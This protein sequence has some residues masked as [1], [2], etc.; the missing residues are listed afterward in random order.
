M[1]LCKE[2]HTEV[3]TERPD[4]FPVDVLRKFKSDHEARVYRLTGLSKDRDTVA[5]VMK[6]QIAG[7]SMDI[8][9]DEMQSAV[10]PNYLR[11]REIVE[12][13]LTKLPDR[14]DTTYWRAACS[15]ID[16]DIDRLKNTKPRENRTLRLS[17]FALGPIPLLIFLGSKLNDKQDVDI[18]QRHRLPETWTWNEG[19]GDARFVTRQLTNEGE[20][21][22][23]LVNVS[24]TNS[25]EFVAKSMG[26]SKVYELTLDGQLPSL[27]VLRTRADLD[28]FTAAYM[29]ALTTI[30]ANHPTLEKLHLF[31]AV[32]APVAIVMGRNRLPKVD[33]PLLV[34][35]RDQRAGGFVATIQVGTKAPEVA[36]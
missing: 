27:S 36:A 34:Y 1:L 15:A 2:C 6:A 11:T 24:G 35:D 20:K 13:D 16:A 5:V 14:A 19:P 31:P 32:P 17:V 4:D 23:L 21:V 29:H 12:I 26:P 30:R 33:P 10:A 8:S 22:A 28:R 9:D 7:R 25:A 3:D 18:Y